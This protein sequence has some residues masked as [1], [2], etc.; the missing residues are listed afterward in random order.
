[1]LSPEDRSLLVD[2]LSAPDGYRLDAA[3]GTTFTLD[4]T[5]L[6][7]VPLAFAGN[8][9]SSGA[10]PLTVLQAIRSYSERIDVFCQAGN[11]RVPS[12]PNDLIAFLEAMVHQVDRPSPGYLFHPK[13]WVLRFARVDDLEDRRFRLLCGSRNLTHDRAWDALI[14]LDGEPRGVRRRALNNPLADFVAGLAERVPTLPEDR[15]RRIL[16]LSA[17]LRN[18]EWEPPPDVFPDD[19]W[20]RFHSFGRVRSPSP[21]ID[22]QRH[23]VVSPFLNDDGLETLFPHDTDLAIVSTA[24]DFDRLGPEIRDW[25]SRCNTRLFTLDDDAAIPAFEDDEAGR[26]W[27]LSGLHAKIYVAER[28]NRAHVFVGSANAT[29]AAWNG[30]DEFLVE[31]VGK[32]AAFGVASMTDSTGF[33]SLLSP[34][35]LGD[36]VPID[37]AEELRRTLENVLRDLVG[38]RFTATL[39]GSD[40]EGWN[41]AIVSDK[42][43]SWRVPD[44]SLSVRL[45][46]TPVAERTATNGRRIAESWEFER[47]EEATPF[48]VLRLSAH[49][50][51]ATTVALARL[52]GDLP[53]RLDRVLARQFADEQTFVRFLM[54]LLRLNSESWAGLDTGPLDAAGSGSGVWS[55][56]ST[57]LLESLM[58][59]LAV[60]PA[61]IGD[62][63]RL[64][65]RLQGTTEGRKVLPPGWD[66]L[67]SVVVEARK[68][69]GAMS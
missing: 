62:V 32:R 41:E 12:K 61:S 4:L 67:W 69:V 59:A 55:A 53:D 45:L 66:D 17:S 2:L 52:T 27:S 43:L 26:R 5:A 29:D 34:Y 56:A 65:E 57:G 31:L 46:T 13:I 50:V 14:A 58:E 64:V 6:L 30:N 24:E 22:G 18:V 40:S 7:P 8:D 42:A 9:L 10:D 16:D 51:E 49:G 20:L 35:E 48:L 3:V 19:D 21:N 44:A 15:A 23:L 36:A 1:M 47:L 68:R 63:E 25:F 54:L 28:G 33:G 39:T 11:I 60:S 37:A 38:R